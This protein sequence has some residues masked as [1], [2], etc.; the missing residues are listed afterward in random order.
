M[1]PLIELTIPWEEAAQAT[2]E[3]KMMKHSELV[4]ERRE[5]GW[6]IIIYPVEVRYRGCGEA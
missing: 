3:R 5:A 6:S 4:A 2:H 1:A